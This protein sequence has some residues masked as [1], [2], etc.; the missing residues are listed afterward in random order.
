MGR[1]WPILMG[2]MGKSINAEISFCLIKDTFN[3]TFIYLI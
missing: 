2:S 3:E 1:D